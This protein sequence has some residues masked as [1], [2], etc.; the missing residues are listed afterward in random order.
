MPLDLG[1]PARLTRLAS[2]VRRQVLRQRRLL[3]AGCAALAVASG[4]AATRTPPPATTAVAVA[5]RDLPAGEVLGRGDLVT[6][7][8]APGSVP[9]GVLDADQVDGRVLA[10]P[11]TRG[12]PLT[13]VGLVGPALT[14]GHDDLR[15]VPVRLPDAG[16]AGLL[17][18]G[19]DIDL[20]ATDPRAGGSE[21]VASGAVVLAVPAPDDAT[22]PTGLA[23]RLVVLGLDDAAVASVTDA[24]AR[25]VV[26]FAWS[27]R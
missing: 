24:A 9:A 17:R 21:T 13:G 8:F 10:A 26:T 25:S 2:D 22:G 18:P 4:L 6:V 27:S 3:A 5:A 20:V 11:V 1:R 14:T 12:Q 19:D 7:A 16:A 15:A 23:G